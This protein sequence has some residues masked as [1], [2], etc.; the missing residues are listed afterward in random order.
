M[1][2]CSSCWGWE[3][4]ELGRFAALAMGKG[5][6]VPAAH[7]NP[8]L[9]ILLLALIRPKPSVIWMLNKRTH[10]GILLE[11]GVEGANWSLA[12]FLF[13]AGHSKDQLKER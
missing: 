8:L 3:D 13:G 1:A 4:G 7:Q 11:M 5:S 2:D 10:G 12:P 6:P 9:D